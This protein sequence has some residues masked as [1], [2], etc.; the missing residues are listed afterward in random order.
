MQRKGNREMPPKETT[1]RRIT[2]LAF[3]AATFISMSSACAH[4][5]AIGFNVPFGFTVSDQ[6]F[7]AGTYRVS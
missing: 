2:A 1:M 6:V 3:I 7:P 4:A 5:Q